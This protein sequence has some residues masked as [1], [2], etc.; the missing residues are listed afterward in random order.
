MGTRRNV[1]ATALDPL[2]AVK[3]NADSIATFRS[4]PHYYRSGSRLFPE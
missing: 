4:L 3:V 1:D 2:F